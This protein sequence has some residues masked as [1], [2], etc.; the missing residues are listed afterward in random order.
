MQADARADARHSGKKCIKISEEFS[1]I[2]I[3]TDIA[4]HKNL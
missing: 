1:S 2:F 3:F 4:L